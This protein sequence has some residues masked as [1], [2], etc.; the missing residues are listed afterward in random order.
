MRAVCQAPAR[1]V[2]MAEDSAAV[3]FT[4]TEEEYVSFC[5]FHATQSPLRRRRVFWALRGY[6]LLMPIAV[7][8]YIALDAGFWQQHGP[9]GSLSLIAVMAVVGVFLAGMQPSLVRAAVGR[10]MR[11]R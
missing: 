2:H 7:G 5:R 8:S 4:L 1:D 11:R 6:F 9:S 10:Q 3:E